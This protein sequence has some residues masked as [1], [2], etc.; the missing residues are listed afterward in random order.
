MIPLRFL[1]VVAVFARPGLLQ[2]QHD[3]AHDHRQHDDKRWYGVAPQYA[4]RR[5]R[6]R[7]Y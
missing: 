3:S 6:L 5:V 7:A 4:R 1:T 2:H